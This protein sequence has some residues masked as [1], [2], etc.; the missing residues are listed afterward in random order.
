[1][2]QGLGFLFTLA[3]NF[4]WGLRL[5]CSSTTALSLEFLL[6]KTSQ[7]KSTR[8][9]M[10]DIKL[11]TGLVK[12]NDPAQHTATCDPVVQMIDH[13]FASLRSL[14]PFVPW[15]FLRELALRQL[16]CLLDSGCGYPAPLMQSAQ[17]Y[18]YQTSFVSTI[19]DQAILEP[20]YYWTQVVNHLLNAKLECDLTTPCLYACISPHL[21]HGHLN[22]LAYTTECSFYAHLIESHGTLTGSPYNLGVRFKLDL[23]PL[24]RQPLAKLVQ[25][26]FH[27][28]WP[29]SLRMPLD[30]SN[31]ILDYCVQPRILDLAYSK[32]EM[33]Y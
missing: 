17:Y 5:G 14:F 22:C 27:A 31:I 25:A 9:N 18:S 24:R 19:H 12:W 13:V 28:D 21:W 33:Y 26:S 30:V 11:S 1:M 32:V 20:F 10:D 8:A 29:A 7:N 3:N 4:S 6:A 16:K 2:I 15:P 23:D